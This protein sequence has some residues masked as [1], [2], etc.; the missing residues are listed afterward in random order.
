[1]IDKA[2]IIRPRPL[3]EAPQTLPAKDSVLELLAPTSQVIMCRRSGNLVSSSYCTYMCEVNGKE[4]PPFD[5]EG[6]DVCC[7]F[8]YNDTFGRLGDGALSEC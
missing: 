3:L 2:K 7:I 1:M 4:N 5:S 6:G 8:A